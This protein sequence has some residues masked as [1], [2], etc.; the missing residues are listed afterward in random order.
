MYTLSACG[1]WFEGNASDRIRAAK[2]NGFDALEILGWKD[3]DLEAVAATL[4]ETGM[5]ISAILIQSRDE[6]KQALIANTHG[7]VWKDAHG[8][9]VDA[10]GE[11]LEAAKI[12]GVTK[13]VVTT[14][15]ERSDVSR[16][17]QHDLIVDAL[18]LGAD[19][20]KGSGVQIVLEP[21]NILVNHMGYFLVTTKES[22]EVINEVGRPEVRLLFDVY[23]QQISEGNVIRNITENIG[24]IG[25]IHVG[26]NPGRLE[27]GTGEINYKNVFKAIKEAGYSEFVVFECGRSVDAETVCRNMLALAE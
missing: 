20:V 3:M 5:K 7:I 27:P 2:K 16:G 8:A 15:N 11:T 6:E 22:I 13:I 24:L 14:G 26:D 23:H 18:K 10:L 4:K 1:G 12:L 17:V 19:V 21:L 9:F 25:H